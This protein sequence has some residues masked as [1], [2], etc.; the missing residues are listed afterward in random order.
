MQVADGIYRIDTELGPRVNTLHCF[1]GPDA[2][3]LFYPGVGGDAQR[4]TGAAEML[5]DDGVTRVRSGS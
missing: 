1:R 5:E 3:L 4:A 2:C